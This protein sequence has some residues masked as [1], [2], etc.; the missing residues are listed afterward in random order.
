MMHPRHS[1][2]E[3][4]HRCQQ[5]CMLAT[6][7]KVTNQRSIEL[8]AN[9][10]LHLVHSGKIVYLQ[11]STYRLLAVKQHVRPHHSDPSTSVQ[12][13]QWFGGKEP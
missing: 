10:S 1:G 5:C 12:A 8:P 11:L 9:S 3:R 13:A 2:L 6:A 7:L 4:S